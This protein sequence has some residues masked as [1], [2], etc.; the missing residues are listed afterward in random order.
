MTVLEV[1]II[2]DRDVLATVHLSK[3]AI[4]DSNAVLN[5][6]LLEVELFSSL[7]VHSDRRVPTIGKYIHC[8]YYS[9]YH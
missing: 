1:F 8:K 5:E 6:S 3:Q 2:E 7:P 9:D 4:Y